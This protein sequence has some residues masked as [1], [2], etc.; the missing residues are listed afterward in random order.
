MGFRSTHPVVAWHLAAS[1]LLVVGLSGQTYAAAASDDQ[2]GDVT[3]VCARPEIPLN[4]SSRELA[5]ELLIGAWIH[6][7]GDTMWSSRPDDDVG[8]Q[9]GADGTF[10]RLYRAPNGLLIAGDGID[11]YGTWTFGDLETGPTGVSLMIDLQLIGGD[12]VIDRVSFSD[13]P[14]S[15]QT[16]D[17]TRFQL[18]DGPD[19]R[20]AQPPGHTGGACGRPADP[21]VTD[22]STSLDEVSDLLIG[23]WI[24]CGD[25]IASIPTDVGVVFE[26]DGRLILLFRADDG[27]IIRGDPHGPTRTWELNSDAHGVE[28]DLYS[29]SDSESA[30]PVFL[31]SPPFLRLWNQAG[32]N[33]D[34][35]R[36]E[37]SEMLA[38][39]GPRATR[40]LVAAAALLV[41]AGLAALSIGPSRRTRLAWASTACRGRR[42]RFSGG[43]RVRR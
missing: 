10:H 22:V 33:A 43:G 5:A 19:P 40:D 23:T 8:I 16:S 15:F 36:G 31:A 37:P 4:P 9:F 27:S 14:R 39:T 35:L 25:I 2:L 38:P 17:D 32:S 3:E 7:S 30:L 41:V 34:Y 21:V 20:V 1:L 18:W 11:E 12:E 42:Q 6:C 24:P 28:L 26:P 29:G 13:V